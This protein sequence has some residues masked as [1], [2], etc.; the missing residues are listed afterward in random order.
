MQKAKKQQ[1]HSDKKGSATLPTIIAF[2]ILI[3]AMSTSLA[4]TSIVENF[5]NHGFM[6]S[7]KAHVYAEAGA[8]DAL[9]RIARNKNYACDAPS[10]GCYEINFIS[11]GC[12]TNDGC[13]RITVS[14][15][16]S[17]KIII[18]EGRVKDNIRKIRVEASFDASSNGKIENINWQEVAN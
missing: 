3:V 4:S 16:S 5:I 18:S 11:Q 1:F 10:S 12:S 9:M 15:S 7:S 2:T 17:P 8:K 14:A 6:Q 13:A